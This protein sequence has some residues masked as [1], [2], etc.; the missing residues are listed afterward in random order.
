MSDTP[1][2]NPAP[3]PGSLGPGKLAGLSAT[4]AHGL[5]QALIDH[6]ADPDTVMAAVRH[7]RHGSDE[8]DIDPRSPDE[9][10]TQE[11]ADAIAPEAREPGDYKINYASG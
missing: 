6:G 11:R 9:I 2:S 1:K 7:D 5:A 4:Q 3:I 8:M 10:K